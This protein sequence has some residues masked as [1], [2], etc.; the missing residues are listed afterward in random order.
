MRVFLVY[1]GRTKHWEEFN[2]TNESMDDYSDTII[3][4]ELAST[5]SL[6]SIVEY[7]SPPSSTLYPEQQEVVEENKGEEENDTPRLRPFLFEPL[8]PADNHGTIG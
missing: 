6:L 1:T 7:H 8:A 2:R 5:T 3:D 4:S